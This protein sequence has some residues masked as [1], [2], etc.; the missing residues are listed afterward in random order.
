MLTDQ[1]EAQGVKICD[2]ESSLL[3]HQHKLNSA[4]EMLQQVERFRERQ[5]ERGRGKMQTKQTHGRAVEQGGAPLNIRGV[6]V[7]TSYS[8][9]LLR[10]CSAVGS[11]L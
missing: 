9:L 1:V 7:S 11:N 3:E 10:L 5:R 2:L 4:E 6:C 8:C